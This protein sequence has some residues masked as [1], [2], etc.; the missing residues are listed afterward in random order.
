[1]G[2]P[3]NHYFPDE[4]FDDLTN[5]DLFTSPADLAWRL[6]SHLLIMKT[7]LTDEGFFCSMKQEGIWF[8][9]QWHQL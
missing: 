4:E 5:T 1:M 3:E 6:S 7:K 9:A 8:L 2:C